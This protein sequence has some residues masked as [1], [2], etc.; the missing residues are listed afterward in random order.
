MSLS[1]QTREDKSVSIEICTFGHMVNHRF[2]P[3]C[4]ILH[5]PNNI[6]IVIIVEYTL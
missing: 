1:A 4:D 5:E 6:N 2:F 3:T